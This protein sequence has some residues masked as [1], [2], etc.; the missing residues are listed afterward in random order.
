MTNDSPIKDIT[1]GFDHYNMMVY[2]YGDYGKEFIAIGL[3]LYP[4]KEEA[5]CIRTPDGGR[6]WMERQ[7]ILEK[8]LMENF[9][10]GSF[11]PVPEKTLSFLQE[12]F[13]GA[14]HVHYINLVTPGDDNEVWRMY[15][16]LF[17]NR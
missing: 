15:R 16:S 3:D 5:I 1:S 4:C 11:D 12:T 2:L 13:D 9:P 8:D 14:D 6:A 10:H 7:P 17:E